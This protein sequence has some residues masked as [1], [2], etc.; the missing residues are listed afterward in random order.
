MENDLSLDL[1]FTVKK[2]SF[3][4]RETISGQVSYCGEG[5]FELTDSDRCYV[6]YF[7]ETGD[8]PM[9]TLGES[10]DLVCYGGDTPV[11]RMEAG[12][13]PS[14]ETLYLGIL[15]SFGLPSEPECSRIG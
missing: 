12:G 7:P 1:A 14:E 15:F 13:T 2:E 10:V 8:Y 4:P 11:Q 3:I 5:L 9:P 6:I